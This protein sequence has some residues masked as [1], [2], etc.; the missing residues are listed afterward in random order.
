MTRMN[1]YAVAPRANVPAALPRKASVW[2]VAPIA[3]AVDSPSASADDQLTSARTR[4]TGDARIA[5]RQARFS[6]VGSVCGRSIETPALLTRP[7]F[8]QE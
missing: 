5:A 4:R 3:T 8:S 1:Q 6:S 7:S 2:I